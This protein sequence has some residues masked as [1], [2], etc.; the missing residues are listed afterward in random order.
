MQGKREKL[1]R[2]RGKERGRE[3]RERESEE[4]N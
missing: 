3:G 4:E 1:E 2:G